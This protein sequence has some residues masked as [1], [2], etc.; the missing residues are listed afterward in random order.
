MGGQDKRGETFLESIPD[1]LGLH[2]LVLPIRA[3]RPADPIPPCWQ[4]NTTTA[5]ARP[6]AHVRRTQIP[7]P[8]WAPT[9]TRAACCAAQGRD[10]LK[11]EGA[12]GVPRQLC[13]PLDTRTGLPSD[14]QRMSPAGLGSL[15]PRQP[16]PCAR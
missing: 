10:R 12:V 8:V 5:A 6:G 14:Q 11:S 15:P 13:R 2:R 4:C 1:P 7:P 9:I 16:S 3:S